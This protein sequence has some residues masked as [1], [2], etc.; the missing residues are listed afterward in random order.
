MDTKLKNNEEAPAAFE[1]PQKKRTGAAAIASLLVVALIAG[2][3][4]LFGQKIY[5]KT[6][7]SPEDLYASGEFQ[8]NI[9]ESGYTLYWMMHSVQNEEI[10]TGAASGAARLFYPSLF[11]GPQADAQP[12]EEQDTQDG[13]EK[14]GTAEV[15]TGEDGES[16]YEDLVFAVQDILHN[17][18]S[19]LHNSW[20]YN[21]FTAVDTA[22]GFVFRGNNAQLLNLAKGQEIALRD[23]Y[24]FYAVLDFDK[25]GNLTLTTAYGTGAETVEI[26]TEAE[27]AKLFEKGWPALTNA[28]SALQGPRNM[29]AVMGI[30]TADEMRL[31]LFTT[32]S[33]QEARALSD[34]GFALFCVAM[35]ILAALAGVLLAAIR[36]LNLNG[37]S[38]AS[39]SPEVSVGLGV[40]VFVLLE[41][42]I[43]TNLF[44]Y[45]YRGRVLQELVDV[46]LPQTA[47]TW[48]GYAAIFVICL[49]LFG[50]AFFAAASLWQIKKLG[51]KQY[52]I[53]RSLVV[54][55]VVF[56]K[57]IVLRFWHWASTI[58]F[59]QKS[60][61]MLARLLFA[62]LLVISFLC[63]LWAGGIVVAVLYTIFL[64]VFL[65][66]KVAKVQQDY[67]QM[68]EATRQMAQGRLDAPL[69]SDFGI[70]EPVK[71]ELSQ[72]QHGFRKAVAAETKSQNMKTELIT[73]VSHDLKTPLTAIITYVDLLQQ[74]GITEEQRQEYVGTLE[75]KSQRLKRLIE[76]LFE[77]SKASS[78]DIVLNKKQVDL[79]ALVKQ[80]VAE[81]ND[82]MEA[83]GLEV[84]FRFEEEKQELA[85]DGEKTSRI[86]ENLLLNAA[87]YS[88][89]GT[90][91]YV[92]GK[93]ENGEAVV[94]IKNISRYALDAQ[95][96][97]LTERFVRGD[98]S[99][100]TEGSGLGLAIVKSFA[101]VQGGRLEIEVDGDLFKARVCFPLAAGELSLQEPD[102]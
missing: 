87:K 43:N 6:K 44:V 40:A 14:D 33:Y 69:D 9:L 67:N 100:S 85:L 3:V 71:Q 42:I 26:L 51:I 11:A 12:G 29:R 23:T 38:F 62:N 41:A 61:K 30:R 88:L 5:Q 57:S 52:F 47:A 2:S 93:T 72:I 46:G 55:A 35:A 99:R 48:L 13:A 50:S 102:F 74:E 34:G 77:V 45:A 16:E 94:E 60:D 75:A 58:N 66:R 17:G 70:F 86:F 8:Q 95:S 65:R 81:N 31:G 80:V 7:L 98:L 73:N 64:F 97:N 83:A 56:G 1:K 18:E 54:R 76:D 49:F 36:P 68:M 32:L 4:L 53:Q 20:N 82:E 79:P 39:L 63:I 92:G 37:L 27:Y 21:D 96:N 89:P 22:T 28:A 15:L 19:F 91:V 78:N 24:S 10:G 90:R 59:S 101:E 84:L 25:D